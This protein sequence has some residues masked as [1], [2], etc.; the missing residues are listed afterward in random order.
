MTRVSS[1]CAH[2]LEMAGEDCT[3]QSDHPG[4]TQVVACR[5]RGRGAEIEGPAFDPFIAAV[6]FDHHTE[7]GKPRGVGMRRISTAVTVPD[8]EA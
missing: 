2:E 4:I 5:R 7:R 3:T 8:V 1:A 6:R